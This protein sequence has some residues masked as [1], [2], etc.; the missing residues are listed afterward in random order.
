M[1]V[2]K[3]AA[4][5]TGRECMYVCIYLCVC[6]S[7]GKVSCRRNKARERGEKERGRERERGGEKRDS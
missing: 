6:E 4:L 3:T 7:E 2:L 5:L 1:V